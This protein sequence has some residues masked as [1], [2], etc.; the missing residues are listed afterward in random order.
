MPRNGSG[1]YGPPAGTAAV[2]NT[3]I[4]SADYN[5]VVADMS[6]ALTDSI[7]VQGTAPYQASQPMGGNKLTNLGAGAAAGDSASLGQT[8]SG[9][10]AH[11]TAVGGTSDAIIATFSPAFSAYTAKMRFRLTA[12][13]A[14]TIAAPTV[15]VDGLGVKTIKKLGGGALSP[16]DIAG[17][18]HICDCVYNGT[19]V[20]LLN[21]APVAVDREQTFTAKQTFS[22]PV[23]T[24]VTTLAD[25]ATIAW[26][27]NATSND[28]RIVLTAS[29]N[30]GL[31]TNINTGQKGLLTIRQDGTGGWVLTPNAIFKQAGGQ[32]V[33]DLDKVANAKTVYSYEVIEDH[34]A[35]KVILIRRLWSENTF[36][37]G[38]YREYNLGTLGSSYTGNTYTQAH[39]LGRRPAFELA[40]LE[41]IS[42]DVG[43]S[44]GDRAFTPFGYAL[45]TGG[46]GNRNGLG[47]SSD[48]TNVYVTFGVHGMVLYRRS[49]GG[50]LGIDGT[51]WRLILRIYE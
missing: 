18:G 42:S 10:V 19:D 38:F 51:K 48:L 17:S 33:F 46:G 32:T 7:N 3:T 4:E 22:K 39:G 12:G 47:I 5:A 45:D 9:V 31:P 27:M 15:N 21:F 49:D 44:P 8:Q 41:C 40:W 37:M 1:I 13:G 24:T 11:A 16:G 23:I 2:P 14:N 30:L 36:A 34:T 29:R 20:I 28:V 43:F 35:A 25:A 6:Q 50:V 26:D